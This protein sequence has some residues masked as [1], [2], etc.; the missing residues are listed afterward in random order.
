MSATEGG[1]LRLAQ[2]GHAALPH[3]RLSA[4]LN[5]YL[6]RNITFL[7]TNGMR[8]ALISDS[9]ISADRMEVKQT[10]GLTSK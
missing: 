4:V 3:N 2:Y 8:E 1:E 9:L 6:W 10:S 7:T 5:T